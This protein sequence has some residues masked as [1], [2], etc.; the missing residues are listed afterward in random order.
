MP[1]FISYSHADKAFV[2]KLAIALVERKRNVW[3][4]KWEMSVGESLI[5]KIQD[6][7]QDASGLLVVLSKASVE[8]NWCK[9]E[10]NGGLIRELDE[11]RIL[12]LPVLIEECDIPMF[13]REKMYADFRDSFDDGLESVVDATAKIAN[14][15]RNRITNPDWHTDWAIDWYGKD[16]VFLI[17]LTMV[18]V[19]EKQPYTTLTTIEIVGDNEANEWY[20]IMNEC[21]A[22]D[23]AHRQIVEALSRTLTEG[24]HRVLLKDHFAHDAHFEFKF[25][26]G[27]CLA[28]LQTRLLGTD[29]GKDV[30]VN[31]AG[32]VAGAVEQMRRAAR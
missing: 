14:E 3:L 29:T 12:V 7:I 26:Y 16:G 5:D 8:S 6:A 18:D 25:E 28:A 21:G 17:R 20:R 15:W 1:F 13:L 24:D 4:D 22:L 23:S 9:K 10:L 32:V 19:W 27:E 31:V 2:N 30:L 11:R